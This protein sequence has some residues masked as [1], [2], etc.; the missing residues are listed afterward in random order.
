MVIE[1]LELGR[2]KAIAGGLTLETV[3]ECESELYSGKRWKITTPVPADLSADFSIIHEVSELERATLYAASA[4]ASSIDPGERDLLAHALARGDSGIWVLA[5]P[6]KAAIATAVE[7]GIG[8]QLVSLEEILSAVGAKSQLRD[9]FT[10][11]WM[12]TE[13]TKRRLGL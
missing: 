7:A 4:R 3:R 2:W 6:D 5:S 12:R 13:I 11:S 10:A 9:H 1:A 8:D